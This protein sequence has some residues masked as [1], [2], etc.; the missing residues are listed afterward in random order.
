MKVKINNK[1]V[2]TS[3]SNLQALA[4]EMNLP[5][6]GVAIAI[7]NNMIPRAGWAEKQLHEGDNIVIIKAACGG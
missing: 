2:E 5:E 7:D 3:V 6:Q 4:T 1:D